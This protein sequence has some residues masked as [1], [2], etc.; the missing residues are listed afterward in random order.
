MACKK[1]FYQINTK[2]SRE[3]DAEENEKNKLLLI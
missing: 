3:L 2:K 1:K